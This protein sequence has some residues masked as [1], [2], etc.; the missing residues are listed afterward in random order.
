MLKKWFKRNC[1]PYWVA[2]DYMHRTFIIPRNPWFNIYFH[3]F[4][5]S[6]GP[7][8]HDHPWWSV[9]VILW[10]RYVEHTYS[11]P[12]TCSIPRKAGDITFRSAR[13]LHRIELITPTYTLFITG[14]IRRRWGF[15]CPNGW[16]DFK[17]YLDRIG[18]DRLANG[19]G[20][21]L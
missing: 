5:G 2:R 16:V 13:Q 20:E 15:Q 10:G 11:E 1:V 3:K 7:A 17:V 8:M 19:C 14:P 21:E 12:W 18:D 6:D 4:V 9:S